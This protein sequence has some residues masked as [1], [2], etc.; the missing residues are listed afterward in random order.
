[1]SAARNVPQINSQG[2]NL[3]LYVSVAFKMGCLVT[4]LQITEKF[5]VIF[6]G[7]GGVMLGENEVVCSIQCVV[8][9]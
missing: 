2:N 4:Q 3:D 7:Q 6:A 8:K 5:Q 1:M 9:C